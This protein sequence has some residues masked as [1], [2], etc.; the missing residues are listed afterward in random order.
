MLSTIMQKRADIFQFSIANSI[1]LSRH[2]IL[3]DPTAQNIYSMDWFCGSTNGAFNASKTATLADPCYCDAFDLLAHMLGSIVFVLASCCVK[4][5]LTEVSTKPK[6]P[7]HSYRWILLVAMVVILA[8]LLAEGLLT[9]ASFDGDIP[10]KPHLYLPPCFALLA[11]VFSSY[12]LHLAETYPSKSLILV[13]CG[14]WTCALCVQIV[15][16]ISLLD[17]G[18]SVLE[19]ARFFFT[20]AAIVIYGFLITLSC[21][22]VQ[23]LYV[24]LFCSSCNIFSST[25]FKE[26]SEKI[27]GCE[28]IGCHGQGAV[29]D[30]IESC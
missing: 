20:S 28:G 2:H 15:R 18:I 9:D 16:L 26:I 3:Q 6:L 17:L 7:L 5:P 22:G 24:T 19:T 23:V 4:K 29:W 10:T 21:L 25:T 11:T 14:Y 1:S 30:S 8:S 27:M 13:I 12:C